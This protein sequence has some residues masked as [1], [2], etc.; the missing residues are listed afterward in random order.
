MWNKEKQKELDRLLKEKEQF[1]C[2]EE[3]L[4]KLLAAHRNGAVVK[5]G[6]KHKEPVDI[7]KGSV[8]YEVTF[9]D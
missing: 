8:T 2:V 1:E 9:Y 3:A 6:I 7:W 4:E 5:V